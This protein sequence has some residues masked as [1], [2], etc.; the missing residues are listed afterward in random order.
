M[1]NRPRPAS[2][3]SRAAPGRAASSPASPGIGSGAISGR[4]TGRIP[5]GKRAAELPM[6]ALV[7]GMNGTVA[8][9]LAQALA[10]AGNAII[11][12]DRA[13]HPIDNPEAVRFFIECEKPDL[14]CHVAMGSPEWTEWTAR[15]C[16]ENKIP[17]LHISSVSVFSGSQSGPFTVHDLPLPDD[18][19]GRC[20]L[21]GERRVQ[22]AHPG[23]HV[24]RIGWQI[25]TAP[26]GNQMIDYL[27]RTFREHGRID[28]STRWFPGC[29]FLPDT[30]DG[31]VQILR[32]PPDLYH[33]D[34]NPGLNFYEIATGLN[35]LLGHPWKV[36]PVSGLVQN[37]RM[38]D[39][40]VPVAPI[41][42]RW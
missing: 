36:I 37:H 16:A 11:P 9:A 39:P 28:A 21:E 23:A 33:L 8:P 24:V 2:A 18:N 17:F 14:F 31:L 42:D 7:T 13:L 32:L 12:W 26:G 30:A 1:R 5:P 6:K 22:T 41:S 10:A 25:G 29:S 40:R 35:K 15:S 20:K 38:L 34:G 27:D 4:N 19:Y 3:A